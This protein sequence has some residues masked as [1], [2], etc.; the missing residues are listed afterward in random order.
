MSNDVFPTLPGQEWP[1]VK[2]P[3][4]KTGIKE[5]VSGR[6]FRTRYMASPRYRI[7]VS[8]EF[9]REWGGLGEMAS[10]LG[11]FNK[12]A[13]AFESFRFNDR[14]DNAAVAQQFGIGDGVTTQFQLLRTRGGYAEPVYELN[15][16]PQIFRA[17]VL[18][19]TPAAYTVNATGLVTFTAAPTAGQSLTWTGSYYWRTRFLSDTTDF[20][21]F[22]RQVWKAQGIELITVKP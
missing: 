6:E 10:L 3:I 18:Q 1:V 19:A 11:F 13:G 22:M 5:T 20:Q 12:H 2:R 21:E 14:D 4:H 7:K 8:Y 9:L 15:G 16:A 17:G